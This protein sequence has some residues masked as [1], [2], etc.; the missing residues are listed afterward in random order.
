M[1]VN[2][3]YAYIRTCYHGGYAMYD[4]VCT[5]Y[6]QWIIELNVNVFHIIFFR[7]FL[8]LFIILSTYYVFWIIGKRFRTLFLLMHIAGLSI[9]NQRIFAVN[10]PVLA[11]IYPLNPGLSVYIYIYIVSCIQP[12]FRLS[13]VEIMRLPYWAIYTVALYTDIIQ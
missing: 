11:R 6:S 5:A 7:L 1:N 12:L 10:G 4:G 3:T 2:I 13:G 8:S 9:C